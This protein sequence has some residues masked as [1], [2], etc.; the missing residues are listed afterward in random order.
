M[1]GLCEGGNEPPGSLKGICKAPRD[2]LPHMR[3]VTHI[4]TGSTQWS[5]SSAQLTAAIWR[6]KSRTSCKQQRPQPG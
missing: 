1:A 2:I 4:R 3:R 5:A 6:R